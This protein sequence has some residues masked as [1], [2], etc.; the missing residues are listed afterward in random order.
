MRDRSLIFDPDPVVVVGGLGL[1][2]KRIVAVAFTKVGIS[3]SEAFGDVE[4]SQS[5][6][7]LFDFSLGDLLLRRHLNNYYKIFL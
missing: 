2:R 1:V 5:V 7:P 4:L 6:L 3:L